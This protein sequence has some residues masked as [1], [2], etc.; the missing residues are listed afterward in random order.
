[1]DLAL[2]QAQIQQ[3]AQWLR[4]ALNKLSAFK[5][6]MPQRPHFSGIVTVEGVSHPNAAIQA[7]LQQRAIEAALCPAALTPWDMRYKKLASV[8]RFSPSYDT[9]WESLQYVVDVL[10]EAFTR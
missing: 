3:R 6:P 9:P 7:V 10:A 2:M 1:M 5:V 8:L 4:A